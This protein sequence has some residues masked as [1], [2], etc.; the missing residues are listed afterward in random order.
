MN[1]RV[2]ITGLGLVTPLGVG[3]ELFWPRLRAGE[4]GIS[5]VKAF[6]RGG[7]PCRLAAEVRDFD[8]QAFINPRNMRKMDRISWLAVAAARLAAADAR[9][10]IDDNTRDR[11]GLLFGSSYGSTDVAVKLGATIFTGGPRQANPIIVPNTVM[12]APAGNAAIEL[13]VRGFNSTVNH[14]SASAETA[15]AY[16]ASQVDKGPAKAILAGGVDVIGEFFYEVL[17]RFKALSGSAGGAEAARPFDQDRNG[18]VLGEGAGLVC[19][20]ALEDAHARGATPYAEILGYG[21][22]S[23]PAP[24]TDWP[25][26]PQGAV[27]ALQR[28]LQSAAL[29]PDQIDLVCASANGGI[30]LDL[31]EARA[32]ETVFGSGPGGP[33]VSAVK[34]A[35]GESF[36]SGGLR[37]AVA[38]L[39]L[40]DG[41]APP[42]LGLSNPVVPLN[43]TGKQA[44]PAELRTALV[45][46]FSH[47]G[48]Y[49]CLVLGKVRD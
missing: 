27:L 19:L 25:A 3:R 1:K 49:A 31:L 17:T 10:V 45:T 22:A 39:A 2:A 34:G 43:F 9:L 4:S 5:E 11:I 48:T 16:A 12:N 14:N 29:T 18:W 44:R 13:G 7:R 42:T 41:L 38:A 33:L 36:S 26:D 37:T 20:E 35:V 28:A 32:L 15:I 40:K 23:S 30:K 6:D 21:L 47:G 8:A 24:L 46:G